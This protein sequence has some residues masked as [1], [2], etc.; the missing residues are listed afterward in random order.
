[1]RV[2]E[3]IVGGLFVACGLALFLIVLERI[4]PNVFVGE[5]VVPNGFDELEPRSTPFDVE[6]P[7]AIGGP[8]GVD[9]GS[10]LWRGVDRGSSPWHARGARRAQKVGLSKGRTERGARRAVA[11]CAARNWL[12]IGFWN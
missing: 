3:G 7:K 8:R 12:G 2:S 9:R 5:R 6:L 4:V 10:L 1:M 11:G